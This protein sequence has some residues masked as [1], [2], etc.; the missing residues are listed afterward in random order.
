[1]AR[2]LRSSGWSIPTTLACCLMGVTNRVPAIAQARK[3]KALA[4]MPSAVAAVASATA[5]GRPRSPRRHSC[6]SRPS[7][8]SQEAEEQPKGNEARTIGFQLTACMVLTGVTL[9]FAV[10]AI[11]TA[12]V[13]VGVLH[14]E[15]SKGILRG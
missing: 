8:L 12:T 6:W 14:V 3:R 13:C 4:A 1:M 15:R 5:A 7:R 9:T 2:A 10:L 11:T